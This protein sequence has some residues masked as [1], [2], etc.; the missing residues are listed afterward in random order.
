MRPDYGS[1]GER[2]TLAF[3]LSKFRVNRHDGDAF[4]RTWPRISGGLLINERGIPVSVSVFE[5]NSGDPKTLLPQIEKVQE[6]F[7]IEQFVMVGDRGMITQTQIDAL[8][9]MDGV[10]WITALRPEAIRKLINDGLLQMGAI[11]R[12][13][14]V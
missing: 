6:R 7:G 13:E 11:R 14:S 9:E 12:A 10:D 2:F 5:G 8:R 4:Y 3:E 1:D